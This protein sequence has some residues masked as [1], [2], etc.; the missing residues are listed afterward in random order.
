M[1]ERLNIFGNQ[2][3]GIFS[4]ATDKYCLIPGT[5]KNT[6]REKMEQ[7]LQVPIIPLNISFKK[8]IGVMMV[9]NSNG[10]LIPNHANPQDQVQIRDAMSVVDNVNIHML[11]ESK[12]NALGNLI[13]ANDN[14]ALI[15]NKLPDSCIEAVEDILGV[16][17]KKTRVGNSLLVGTKLV[18][19]GHG[20]LVSP[21]ARDEQVDQF[22]NFFKV[23]NSDFTTVNLGMES[24]RIGII[25]NS[26]GALVGN[27]TSG[28]ELARISDILE[29]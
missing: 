9:G 27:P 19:N 28:P 23:D 26:H 20:V 6:I 14:G 21:L 16:K 1:L 22:K 12:L 7:I 17:V 29:I 10:L 25:S 2:A 18:V 8:L 15:S 13:S 11:E 24:I 5:F 3:I 4:C